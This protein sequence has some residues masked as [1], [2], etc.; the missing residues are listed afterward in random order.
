MLHSG[1][2]GNQYTKM[3]SASHGT[4]TISTKERDARVGNG[5]N[6]T[7]KIDCVPTGTLSISTKERDE[8]TRTKRQIEAKEVI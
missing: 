4:D 8:K 7:R 2:K 3:V 6:D 1:D 5:G